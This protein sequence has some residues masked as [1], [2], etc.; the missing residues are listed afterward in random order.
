MATITRWD[1]FA[2]LSRLHDQRFSRSLG[3]DESH[4]PPVDIHED[5]AAFTVDVEVPGVAPEDVHV[6]VE[7]G[8]L[9][10]RGERK[11]AREEEKDGYRRVERYF[12]SFSRSFSLPE[13][14]D[15]DGIAATASHGVLSIR[16]PKRAAPGARRIDVKVG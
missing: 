7:K 8:I 15:P 11:L 6:D 13:N 5:A 2:E 1:P 3:R 12:G 14:V 9:T 10:V 16:L 4:K